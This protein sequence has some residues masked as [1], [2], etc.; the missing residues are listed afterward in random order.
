[1]IEKRYRVMDLTAVSFCMENRLPVCV[2]D[3]MTY[4]NLS[5]ALQGDNPGTWIF[6]TKPKNQ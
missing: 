2:F 3:L 5:R 6:E 4:G 1:V